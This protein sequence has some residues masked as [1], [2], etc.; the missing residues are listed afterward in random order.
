MQMNQTAIYLHT[1]LHISMYSYIETDEP[2]C[3]KPHKVCQLFTAFDWSIIDKVLI[4]WLS[5]V[6]MI[7]FAMAAAIDQLLLVLINYWPVTCGSGE[8][9]PSIFD[10]IVF[11][12]L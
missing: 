3:Q 9:W 8:K 1:Y 5:L 12:Q 2:D 6:M 10:Q 7:I 11:D 4:N